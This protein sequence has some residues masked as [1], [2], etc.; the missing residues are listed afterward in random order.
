MKKSEKAFL[1]VIIS[2][3]VI[4]IVQLILGQTMLSHFGA[5][6][7]RQ[8]VEDLIDIKNGIESNIKEMDRVV[9]DWA[10]WDDTYNFMKT[11]SRAYIENNLVSSVFENLRINFI[12]FVDND[13][14]IFWGQAYNLTTKRIILL[15]DSLN[16]HIQPNSTI[17]RLC[18]KENGLS[19]IIILE[20]PTIFSMH[21]ILTSEGEGPS[22]GFFVDGTIS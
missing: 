22:M 5:I 16:I 15:P 10:Y 12:L 9:R 19:G 8:M 2:T 18:I 7:K 20:K 4:I 14:K 21:Q 11:K 6:E 1:I 17:L 3:I 13:G